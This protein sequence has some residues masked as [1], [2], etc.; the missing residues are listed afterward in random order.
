MRGRCLGCNQRI[1]P[2]GAV[3][4]VKFV[5]AA[6]MERADENLR[7]GH[8]SICARD[9]LASAHGIPAS[10]DLGDC[11][12]LLR[13]ELLDSMEKRKIAGGI[14]LDLARAATKTFTLSIWGRVSPPQPARK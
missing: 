13:Q 8:A 12:P 3:E 1:E 14:N 11:R 10:V 7:H 9:H 5:I 4:L 2:A 6:H